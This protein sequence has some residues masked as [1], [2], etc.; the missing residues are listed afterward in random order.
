MNK[1]RFALCTLAVF[2]LLVTSLTAQ[3][4]TMTFLD[5]EANGKSDPLDAW[6]NYTADGK[7]D[8]YGYPQINSMKVTWDEQSGFLQKVVIKLRSAQTIRFDSL[9]IDTDFNSKDTSWED[10]D[11][12]VHT[13]GKTDLTWGN[14]GNIKDSSGVTGATDPTFIPDDGLFSVKEN[15]NPTKGYTY[16]A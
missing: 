14:P 10:W 13:G 4:Q 5:N 7:D 11:Y 3:S 6:P 12:F 1:K 2:S 8:E 15:F 16:V 9:F